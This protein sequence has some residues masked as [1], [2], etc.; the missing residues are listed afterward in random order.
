[1]LKLHHQQMHG[2]TTKPE[3][4]KRP[5]NTMAEDAVEVTDF[6]RF[7]FLFNQYKKLSG[8]TSEAP[9]HLLECLGTTRTTRTAPPL[10]TR[11]RGS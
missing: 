3:K 11:R 6:N 9:S 7:A 10:L 5:E 1:M 4:P 8:I 2:T